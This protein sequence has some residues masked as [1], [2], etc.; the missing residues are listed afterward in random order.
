MTPFNPAVVGYAWPDKSLDDSR[1]GSGRLVVER[2]DHGLRVVVDTLPK[3][4]D[5]DRGVLYVDTYTDG[6]DDLK[7]CFYCRDAATDDAAVIVRADRHTGKL[8]VIVNTGIFVE[9]GNQNYDR[10]SYEQALDPG[11]NY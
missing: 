5:K 6:D 1:S 8:T 10:T 4:D 7:F 9:R 11:H 2:D 3:D